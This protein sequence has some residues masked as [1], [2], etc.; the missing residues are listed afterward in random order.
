MERYLN[1]FA[2]V[3]DGFDLD[4]IGFVMTK[5]K[6][7]TEAIKLRT[8]AYPHYVFSN[9]TYIVEVFEKLWA[10]MN[11]KQKNLAVFHTMCAVPDGGFDPACKY[12]GKKV[13]P[14]IVMYR[15]EYAATGGVPNWMEND[16]ARDPMELKADDVVVA[17][18]QEIEDDDDPIPVT[19]SGKQPVTADDIANAGEPEAA[20]VNA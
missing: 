15:L 7:S 17:V 9:K 13:R 2:M 20:A 5:K 4:A 8:V 11:S 12:Y 19:P 6:K 14:E 18:T 3:F 10:E 1:K 16:E